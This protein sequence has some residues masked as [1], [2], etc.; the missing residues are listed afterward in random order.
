MSSRYEHLF[1]AATNVLAHVYGEEVIYI[2]AAGEQTIVSKAI[3]HNEQNEYVP[4]ADGETLRRI[5]Y[6][7][8]VTDDRH[9]SYSGVAVP[10]HN[11]RMLVDGRGYAID[12]IDQPR[13]GWAI[14]K[15]ARDERYDISRESFGDRR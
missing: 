1:S 3:V 10:K 5:R 12:R 4:T 2:S 8:F 15:L 7:E 11:G 14:I 13:Y 9:S 6:V